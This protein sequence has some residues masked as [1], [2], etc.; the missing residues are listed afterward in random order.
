M[1]PCHQARGFKKSLLRAEFFSFYNMQKK[2]FTALAIIAIFG[3]G[4]ILYVS[5]QQP[6][7]PK[8]QTPVIDSR[9]AAKSL[10]TGEIAPASKWAVPTAIRGVA[11]SVDGHA[12]SAAVSSGTSVL[13][14][15]RALAST[16][17]F[18]F[19]GKE[20]PSLGFFVESINGKKN[21]DGYYWILYVNDKESPKGVSETFLNPGDSVL[22]KYEKGY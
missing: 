12:Y 20:Y 5:A 6:F 22:W 11:V 15:M 2:Y 17:D 1:E 19:S 18:I 10:E 16:T 14:A 4:R 13:N 8:M 9:V 21:S 3:I 7:L